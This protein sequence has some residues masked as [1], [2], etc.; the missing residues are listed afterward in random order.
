LDQSTTFED[1][2]VPIQP[3]GSSWSADDE[4]SKQALFKSEKK[5]T[6]S[7]QDNRRDDKDEPSFNDSF[8]FWN[9][10]Q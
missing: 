9:G 6:V 1:S 8:A 3:T 7:N 10:K 5:S 4:F 2:W